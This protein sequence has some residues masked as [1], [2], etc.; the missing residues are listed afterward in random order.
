MKELYKKLFFKYQDFM[1]YTMQAANEWAKPLRF[2]GEFGIILTFLVTNF[3]VNFS[4]TEIVLTYILLMF[5]AFVLGRIFVGMGVA[6]YNNMLAN[7]QNSIIME[8]QKDVKKIKRIVSK[9]D[10]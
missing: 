9:K 3:K 1:F 6:Q 2:V 7:N 8:I 5:V 4:V 10:N